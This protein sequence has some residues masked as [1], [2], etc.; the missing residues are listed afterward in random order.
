MK[1]LILLTLA[2]TCLFNAPNAN[3]N[4]L[5]EMGYHG[6][7]ATVTSVYYLEG[8]RF[9]DTWWPN[10]PIGQMRVTHFNTNGNIDT[11]WEYTRFAKDGP[12][13]LLTTTT[14]DIADGKKIRQNRYD[15]EGTLITASDFK[16]Q[17]AQHYSLRRE[18]GEMSYSMSE[19]MLNDEGM[20]YRGR[21]QS[22]FRDS[23]AYD[24]SY[25]HTFGPDKTIR[26]S[27]M[28][29]EL[30]NEKYRLEYLHGPRDSYEN[31]VRTAIVDTRD[32]TLRRLVSR[33]FTYY[34]KK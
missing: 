22:Y 16:W 23:L 14:H 20:D 21:Y 30:T 2:F 19:T 5:Q 26:S 15:F 9:N 29:D 32:E 27:A 24:V 25:E 33:S 34:Y 12:L 31:V 7:V 3:H 10:G 1:P 28:Q 6:P 4:D 18:E 8:E 17:D 13:E 11:I